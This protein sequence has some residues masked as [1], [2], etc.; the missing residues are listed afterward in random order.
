MTW[1]VG[2]SASAKK[3]KKKL[4]DNIKEALASLVKDIEIQGPIRKDWP[5]F[6]SLGKRGR[7]IP[8][9]AYHCHLKKGKPT[10]V[11]CWSI[12]DKTVKLIEIFYVGTH[13]NAP[14]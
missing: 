7:A 3:T 13:E 4:P 12:E 10:Y 9:S 5:N 1:E 8:A 11:A 14:Y 6:S 2:F